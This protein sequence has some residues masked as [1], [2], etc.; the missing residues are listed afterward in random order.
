GKKVLVVGGGDSA[1]EAAVALAKAEGTT[2]WLSYRKN[3]FARVKK[4]NLE[5]IEE[6]SKAG[7]VEIVWESAVTEVKPEGAV[8]KLAAGPRTLDCVH[9]FALIGAD[10]PRGWIEKIGIPFVEKQE[11]VVS[12]S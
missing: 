4:R 1:I 5:Q 3:A 2:V 11:H 8:L 10:P 12:W 7:R 9:V 6:L